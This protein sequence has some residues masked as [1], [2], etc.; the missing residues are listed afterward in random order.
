MNTLEVRGHSSQH[1]VTVGQGDREDT[2]AKT[3][4]GAMLI[5]AALAV[6]IALG[7]ATQAVA[8]GDFWGGQSQGMNATTLCTP[9]PITCQECLYLDTY[10]ATDPANHIPETKLTNGILTNGV[11]YEIVI[12]G[13][14]SYWDP[15]M[16]FSPIGATEPAPMYPSPAGNKT[17]P[18]GWDWEYLFGYPDQT[19]TLPL[20]GVYNYGVIST[21]GGG[22][23]LAPTPITGQNYNP[24]HVYTFVVVGQGQKAGFQRIDM[25]PSHDNYGRFKICIYRLT[26][27]HT[28]ECV[29]SR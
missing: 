16:W 4:S 26:P 9:P 28:L 20:P 3:S 19:Y 29:T 10:N 27:C 25:G 15:W 7:G 24:A 21:D 17:G 14:A 23:F 8:A 1:T 18:V 13:T 11:L 2:M 6:A 12:S 5:G 22:L